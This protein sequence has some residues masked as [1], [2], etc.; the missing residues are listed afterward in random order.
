VIP[1]MKLAEWLKQ[2]KTRRYAFAERIGVQPSVISDY[3]KGRYCPRPKVAEAIIRETGGQVT[4]ND[5]LSIA[6][7]QASNEKTSETAE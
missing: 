1:T 4:A 6:P 7:E 2:T 5:F 3:C